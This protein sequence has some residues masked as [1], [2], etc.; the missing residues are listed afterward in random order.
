L[1]LSQEAAAIRQPGS[2]AAWLFSVARRTALKAR[3]NRRRTKALPPAETA[4]TTPDPLDRMSARELLE[5]L[6]AELAR[7][8]LSHRSAVLLCLIEGKTVEEAARQLAA[9][10]GSVRGWLQRGRNRLRDRLARRGLALSAVL[11]AT[12][13]LPR[14]EV[15]P[16]L[17][18][19]SEVRRSWL[20]STY[21]VG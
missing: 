13:L 7:L 21:G 15:E 6:D 11:A 12:A 10:E 16:N 17:W 2:L 9:T 5:A 8:P 1:T 20:D 14:T 4:C 3:A 18:S 19:T